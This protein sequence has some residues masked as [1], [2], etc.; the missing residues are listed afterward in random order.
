M[1]SRHKKR[2]GKKIALWLTGGVLL[3]AAAGYV[4]GS[5]YYQKNFLPNTIVNETNISNQSVKKANEKL[6]KQ[7]EGHVFTLTDNGQTY[8]T[9]QL[10]DF[11]KTYDFTS[12]LTALQSKQN[13]WSWPVDFFKKE[14]A[15]VGNLAISDDEV[16]TYVTNTLTPTLVTLNEG[17]TKSTNAQLVFA[18]G[19]F[20]IQAEVNGNY[21][22]TDKIIADFKTALASGESS[23]ELEDYVVKA[24]VTKDDENLKSEL[25]Q[26]QK[27]AAIT[28]TYTINENTVTIPAETIQS[29]LTFTDGQVGL[30]QESVKAY[31]T[32]LGNKYNTSSN[33]YTF[34]STKRGEVSVPAGSY[35]WSIQVNNETAALSEAILKGEDFTRTP[36]VQGAGSASGPRIGNTYVEVD[37]ENQHMWY[38]KDGAVVLETDVVTGKP[39]TP[40]PAGVFYIWNKE[41]NA[42]LSGENGDGSSYATPV[43]YWM[44]INWTGVGIHDASWQPTFGGDWYQAHGSHGC[45]NTP[46]GVMAT[47]FAQVSTD[48]PVLV[49]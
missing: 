15:A 49:F 17:R 2:R 16:N 23:L 4:G 29:W 24:T 19:A 32:E 21:L 18:N 10:E 1:K 20:S 7:I 22:D 42:T 36:L 6:V 12:E 14:T 11:G 48:T 5:L 3:V 40:T 44:P 46:P 31:V 28:A 39:A 25:A 45:V 41:E 8:Q 27:I 33:P 34:Q 38:Y 26:A 43:S 13:P 47:L 9:I 35:S 37:M 30:N